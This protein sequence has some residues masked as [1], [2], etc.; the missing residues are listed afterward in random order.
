MKKFTCI[1]VLLAAIV[2][3]A[4]AKNGERTLYDSYAAIPGL[5]VVTTMPTNPNK[6]DEG[7]AF[8]T[9]G[10]YFN[11]DVNLS[12]PKQASNHED[13]LTALRT[14][15][16]AA[17]VF[18]GITIEEFRDR[19]YESSGRQDKANTENLQLGEYDLTDNLDNL[20]RMVENNYIF[21]SANKPG[22]DK[23]LWALYRI[24][25]PR[26]ESGHEGAE[27]LVKA[28]SKSE[29][30]SLFGSYDYEL[31][32]CG[33]DAYNDM[34]LA[35]KITSKANAFASRGGVI[36]SKSR[37]TA[38]R[39]GVKDI[40][41]LNNGT[42]FYAYGTRLDKQGEP[43]SKKI[44]V[45]RATQIGK[46]S[47]R[48]LNSTDS[49]LFYNIGGHHNARPGDVLVYKPDHKMS[50]SIAGIYSNKM[51]G[52]RIGYDFLVHM[53]KYG[54]AQYAQFAANF[55]ITADIDKNCYT[56]NDEGKYNHVK[57]YCEADIEIGYGL[58]FHVWHWFEFRPYVNLGATIPFLLTSSGKDM[59]YED[60]RHGYNV[61]GW[62]EKT[63][64]FTA[65]PGLMFNMNVAY[66]LQLTVGAEYMYI[67]KT[68]DYKL[69]PLQIVY[70]RKSSGFN[71]YAGFRYC[72]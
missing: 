45:L 70:N 29:F 40:P 57:N 64:C 39:I 34:N 71:L 35:N 11:N 33:E 42:R 67:Y 31:V 43:Y 61:T 15:N 12:A 27:Q 50:I 16:A 26:G 24:V 52:G 9:L 66:P 59:N 55:L 14:Q 53:N 19:A 51:F 36:D 21:I 38:S 13:L 54:M 17:K 65:T 28:K 6:G 44:A 49:T 5:T 25:V 62:D 68:D 1:A 22:T 3:N 4:S 46:G 7:T 48:D 41:K 47:Q 18:E 56:V 30:E 2:C 58:G 63:I 32:A 23:S 72:F 37:F 20:Q 8:E 69:S 60:L 10:Y